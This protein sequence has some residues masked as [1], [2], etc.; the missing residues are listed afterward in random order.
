MA[1]YRSSRSFSTWRLKRWLRDHTGDIRLF[2][3]V[4]K[5]ELLVIAALAL[6]AFLLNLHH[7]SS[8]VATLAFLLFLPTFA[9]FM[10]GTHMILG[11]E[12][13]KGT[14]WT[15]TPVIGL[16][17]WILLD[18]VGFVVLPSLVL[19]HLTGLSP[20]GPL[21][22]LIEA[23]TGIDLLTAGLNFWRSL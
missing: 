2:G 12:Y 10:Y 11:M 5:K 6:V 3:S 7:A 8:T 19:E 4:F 22:R 1:T 18:V 15:V 23:F 17:I 20:L 13:S 16:C 14:A 9:W 21:Y